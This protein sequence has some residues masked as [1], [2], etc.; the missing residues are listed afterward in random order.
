MLLIYHREHHNYNPSTANGPIFKRDRERV[1]NMNLDIS[2][3]VGWEWPKFTNLCKHYVKGVASRYHQNLYQGASGD[4]PPC[5]WTWQEIYRDPQHMEEVN[6]ENI[7]VLQAS[8]V[9][10]RRQ[11]IKPPC[12][13]TP[14]KISGSYWWFPYFKV[15]NYVFL[16]NTRFYH[17][18]AYKCFHVHVRIILGDWWHSCYC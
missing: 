16:W 13:H 12:A 7:L 11:M 15:S 2:A 1:R 9:F 5:S 8:L 10:Y 3:W 14:R 18:E 4:V 6:W 17:N